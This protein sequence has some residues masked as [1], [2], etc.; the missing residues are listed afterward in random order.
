M[1]KKSSSLENSQKNLRGNEID[2]QKQIHPF[3]GISKHTWG[4]QICT[5][6]LLGRKYGIWNF[7]VAILLRTTLADKV[8][9]LRA[10]PFEDVTDH[11]QNTLSTFHEQKSTTTAEKKSTWMRLSN[12]CASQFN[13]LIKS[14]IHSDIYFRYWTL[15]AT[16]H[17]TIRIYLLQMNRNPRK[18]FFIGHKLFNA[19]VWYIQQ[20]KT[21]SEYLYAT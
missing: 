2:F 8:R 1:P 15:N 10:L 11:H 7:E 3:A 17:A 21:Y 13:V 16:G 12:C 4:K 14:W 6:I 5:D 18:G 9:F 20:G 19:T